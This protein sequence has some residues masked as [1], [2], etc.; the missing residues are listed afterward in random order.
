MCVFVFG[1]VWGC[2]L[3]VVGDFFV[4]DGVRF[5]FDCICCCGRIIRCD[6][7]VVFGVILLV[8]FVVFVDFRVVVF[9]EFFI[10]VGRFVVDYR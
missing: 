8:G 10:F 9:V 6:D 1:Y 4:F 7:I 2:S 5:V 3:F